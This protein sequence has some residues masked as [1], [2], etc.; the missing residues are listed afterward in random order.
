L[1]RKKWVNMY[2]NEWNRM[3]VIAFACLLFFFIGA[4]LGAIIRKG[5]LGTP[6]VVSVI[7]FIIY[8][9][10]SLAGEKYARA[11]FLPSWAGMWAASMI[12]LPI[13]I[14]LIFK[15]NRDSKLMSGESYNLLIKKILSFGR[16]SRKQ[17]YEDSANNQ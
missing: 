2:R 7:L 1:I 15:S 8:H 13:A 6:V 16:R 12:L 11:G 17:G 3:M 5:G 14:F 4:P 10:L 9:I